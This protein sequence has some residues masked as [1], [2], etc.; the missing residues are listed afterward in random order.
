MER[1]FPGAGNIKIILFFNFLSNRSARVQR[2][3]N[4]IGVALTQ[5][6]VRFCLEILSHQFL[7]HLQERVVSEQW[8]KPLLNG[9][10]D[11]K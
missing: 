1:K 6:F 3:R 7:P 8:L 10:L 5:C 9:F 4:Q 11:K 2:T